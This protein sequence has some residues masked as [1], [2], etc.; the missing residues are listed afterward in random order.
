MSA[1]SGRLPVEYVVPL[2]RSDDAAD[3]PEST[4]HL[5]RRAGLVDV[6]VVDGSE[7]VAECGRRRRH[8]TAAFG[9]ADAVW[10]PL[11]VGERAVTVWLAVLARLRGGVRYRGERIP[12]AGTRPALPERHKRR[13][14]MGLA[15]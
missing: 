12:R 5:R 9:P 10:A 6:T 11:W 14:G 4:D 15:A 2:R 13:S 7:P 1:G 3:L 8:G